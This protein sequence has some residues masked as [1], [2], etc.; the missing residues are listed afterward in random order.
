LTTI[1]KIGWIIGLM[2]GLCAC[3]LDSTDSSG[4]YSREDYRFLYDYNAKNLDGHTIRWESNT[5]KV[6]T[7]G[8]S[9]AE[10]SI[11]KWA[12]PMSFQYVGSPPSDGISFSYFTSPQYC[13]VTYYSFN[14]A[15]KMIQA[16][17]EI[18]VNQQYCKGG[19]DNTITHEMGHALGFLGHTSDG[20]LMDPDGGNGNI[21]TRLR[22][23]M[24]LLYRMPYGTNIK[25]YLSFTI[26]SPEEQYQSNGLKVIERVIY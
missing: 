1:L 4:D 14:N 5:V 19:Q 9:G 21:T 6:Y 12:G 22:N 17:I 3:H 24:S 13:G 25:P 11:E 8:I 18:N 20:S 2:L 23:F 16:R 26:Q 7:G 15:G 10:S